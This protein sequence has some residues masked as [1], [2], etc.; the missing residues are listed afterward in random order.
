VSA[1][2]NTVM[3]SRIP[4]VDEFLDQLCEYQLLKKGIPFTQYKLGHSMWAWRPPGRGG[5]LA[6]ELGFNPFMNVFIGSP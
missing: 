2:I 1:F 3:Y 6:Y 5:E 4:K